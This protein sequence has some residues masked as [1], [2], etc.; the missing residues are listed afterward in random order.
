MFIFYIF[1]FI[2]I[3]AT[4]VKDISTFKLHKRYENH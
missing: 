2:D 4:V 3:Y 1:V